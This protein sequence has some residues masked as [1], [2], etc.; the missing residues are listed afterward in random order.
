V[1]DYHDEFVLKFDS[2]VPERSEEHFLRA[3]TLR[4]EGECP[5]FLA[6]VR[7]HILRTVQGLSVLR[8]CKPDDALTRIREPPP[9]ALHYS[10]AA[11]GVLEAAHAAFHR[12]IDAQAARAA[13]ARRREALLQEHQ[14]RASFRARIQS[15]VEQYRALERRE[16][17]AARAARQVQQEERDALQAQAQADL[18]RQDGLD[19]QQQRH[20]RALAEQ[21]DLYGAESV[22]ELARLKQRAAQVS[23]RAARSASRR[24]GGAVVAGKR[25]LN[26]WAARTVLLLASRA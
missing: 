17:L 19:R 15:L 1:E 2:S 3:F 6:N 7:T 24:W 12:H 9:L 16:A 11:V 13:L 8:A 21:F 26:A 10:A 25:I 14:L 18:A 23:R 22:E 20:A 4:P 5:F